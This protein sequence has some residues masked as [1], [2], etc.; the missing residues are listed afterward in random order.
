MHFRLSQTQL[1]LFLILAL[2]LPL[3][4]IYATDWPMLRAATPANPQ[5]TFAYVPATGHNIG[6]AI[7]RFYETHGGLAIF[8]L[9][10]TE[11]IEQDGIQVQ[12][13]ERA[14]FELHPELPATY[15]VSLT[16]VGNLLTRD[17]SDAAFGPQLAE[18]GP[19][20]RTLFRTTGHTLGGVF[21]E[22]W[23]HNGQLSV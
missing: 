10:L 19:R 12:Y 20:A 14:R 1:H 21:S 16:L 18:T 22:F 23:L 17:R 2:T 9:P 13:F 11:L 4:A 8:G 5:S 7:K 15:Y 3:A 6:L